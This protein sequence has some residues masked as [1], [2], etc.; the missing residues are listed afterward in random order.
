M[1]SSADHQ[2][3]TVRI[4]MHLPP[5]QLWGGRKPQAEGETLGRRVFCL[6]KHFHSHPGPFFGSCS[7]LLPNSP[8]GPSPCPS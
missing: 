4:N 6:R 2:G 8:G 1:Q 5:T 7:E 3:L